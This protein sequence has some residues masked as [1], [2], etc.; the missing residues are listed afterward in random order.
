MAQLN[1]QAVL[2]VAD[3]KRVSRRMLHAILRQN[4]EEAELL[5]CESGQQAVILCDRKH[6]DCAVVGA[7]LAEFGA[8]EFLERL[9]ER[10]D[11]KRHVSVVVIADVEHDEETS[12]SLMKQGAYDVLAK[13]KYSAFQLT[14]SVQKAIEHARLR[15]ELARSQ[16]QLLDNAHRSGMAEIAGGILHNIGNN[17]NSLNISLDLMQS[18][19]EQSK[20]HGLAKANRILEDASDQLAAHPKGSDLLAYYQGLEG[21]FNA[22]QETLQEELAKVREKI[23]H[24]RQDVQEQSRYAHGDL[25]LEEV[26]ISRIVKDAVS[27]HE[28][29]IE[30]HNIQVDTLFNKLPRCRVVRIKAIQI[31]SNL[32]KNG[33]EALCERESR[34]VLTITT[35]A[36]DSD[37]FLVDI[38]NNGPSIPENI[39]GK[40]FNYGFTTHKGA[41]GM[42]LHAAANAASQM[43]GALKAANMECDRGCSFT[44]TMPFQPCE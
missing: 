28:G 6:V 44:L 18:T 23:N 21:F 33:I 41:G 27:M 31:L 2:L 43:G 32:I 11:A 12:V 1:P 30:K 9:Q 42:G 15:E 24:I 35:R 17:L 25:F 39:L 22:E 10:L 40:I 13:G 37:H 34:R 38:S 4:F 3:A 16:Q 14:R 5:E 26:D 29:R 8:M 36:L 20:L 7:H 19:V